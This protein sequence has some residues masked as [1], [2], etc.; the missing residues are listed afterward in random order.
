MVAFDE[1]N[2]ESVGALGVTKLETEVNW[3]MDSVCSYHMYTKK[4]CFE[5][6]ERKN[7]DVFWLE[8]NKAWTVHGIWTVQLKMFDNRKFLLRNVR[9]VTKIN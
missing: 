4:E 6:L 1:D 5:T 7:C 8:N 3:N 9:H 2:Y